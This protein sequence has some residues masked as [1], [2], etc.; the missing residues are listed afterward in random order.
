MR[1][2]LRILLGYFIVVGVAAFFVLRVFVAEVK[3]SV[4]ETIEEVMVDTANLLAEL[5]QRE[6]AAG[7]LASGPF[8]QAVAAY[9][10]RDVSAK[11]WHYDK[12]SLDFD[13]YVT[14]AQ[15]KVVFDS[16]GRALGQD[17]SR[18]RDVNR[19]LRGAYG[20]RSTRVIE[21]DDNSAV[22]HVAA[23]LRDAQGAIIG[24]LTV[25]K[26]VATVA[27]IIERAERTI[28]K[29]GLWLLA[30]A[31]LV[32]VLMSWWL[33]RAVGKLVDFAQQA[34]RGVATTPPKLAVRELDALGNAM[35]SMR[36]EIEGRQYVEQYVQALTHELKSP[37]ASVRAS[38][39]VLQAADLPEADRQRF[40]QLVE[41]QS[42]RLTALVDRVLA[43]ARLEGSAQLD[44]AAPVELNALAERTVASHRAA[45]QASGV[46]I[47][48][49]P[50]AEPI[51]VQGDAALL[52]LALSNL[53]TNAIDASV[54]SLR[55]AAQAV[56]A[57]E[58]RVEQAAS[59][60]LLV[61]RDH[62][63]GIPDYAL[64]RVFERFY[65]LPRA[66]GQRGTGLGLAI[67]A[68]VAA[69]HGAHAEVINAPGG[70]TLARVRF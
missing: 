40:A 69:R 44:H 18:W 56:A 9:R 47:A 16:T 66:D 25:V 37:L 62:G 54:Q 11:I 55:G 59:R 22:F 24:V 13:I 65:S 57:I 30:A 64:P 15:G 39:E 17:Y 26:P 68:Q 21:G 5:A 60:P 7:S 41:E 29:H 38:S 58:V 32:G 14:D 31:A 12:E 42:E 23:P 33:T 43:L 10:Q 2:S 45:A 35:Q 3:P 4:R 49:I 51:T 8:S 34:Q 63:P 6:V 46:D 27:P 28:L 19:T 20:A 61:V 1:L 50:S 67:V 53:L 70:G 48:L 36:Q 52:E